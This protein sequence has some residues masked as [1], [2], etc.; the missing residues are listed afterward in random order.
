MPTRGLASAVSTR[1]SSQPGVTR[2]SLLSS[3][4]WRPR[5][6]VAPKLQ[7]SRKPRLRSWRRNRM[8][9]RC[10]S[11]STVPSVEASSTT[12]TSAGVRGMARAIESRHASV[13]ARLP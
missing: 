2:V 1:R 5:A 11:A 8:S 4:R 9:W 6:A 12:M 13:S 3:S 10:S 7:V